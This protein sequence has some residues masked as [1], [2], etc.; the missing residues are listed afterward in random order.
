MGAGMT[1]EY[2]TTEAMY[3]GIYELLKRGVGF[4]CDDAALKITLTGG[5]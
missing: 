5:F 4:V 3:E 2:A 1:I